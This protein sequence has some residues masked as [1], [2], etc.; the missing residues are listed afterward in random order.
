MRDIIDPSLNQLL[1]LSDFYFISSAFDLS[2]TYGV[3]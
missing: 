3:S 1:V 2:D